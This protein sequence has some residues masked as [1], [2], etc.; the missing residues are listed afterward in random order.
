MLVTGIFLLLAVLNVPSMFCLS[1]M[2]AIGAA[3]QDK[4]KEK[5]NA[6]Y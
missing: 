4:K 5:T 1:D 2:K 6:M 3:E